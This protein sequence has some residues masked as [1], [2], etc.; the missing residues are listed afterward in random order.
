[1]DSFKLEELIK[2]LEELQEHLSISQGSDL[3]SLLDKSKN[4]IE[5]EIEE[6]LGED[7]KPKGIAIEKVSIM[8]KPKNHDDKVGE[9]IAEMGDEKDKKG[10]LS[11]DEEE[12]TD[13]ELEELSRKFARS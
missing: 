13:E 9:A 10:M 3:K 5:P 11:D 6:E 2:G 7:G 12:M 1:M 4:P 8:G